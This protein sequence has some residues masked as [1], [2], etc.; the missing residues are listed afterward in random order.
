[1]STAETICPSG[2]TETGVEYAVLENIDADVVANRCLSD[3]RA[4]IANRVRRLYDQ[5][6]GGILVSGQISA[7]LQRKLPTRKSPRVRRHR[8]FG[9]LGYFQMRSLHRIRRRRCGRPAN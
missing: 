6:R 2:I 9:S 7:H 5:R 8:Q 1:M 4:H 3:R